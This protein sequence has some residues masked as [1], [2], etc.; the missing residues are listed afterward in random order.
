MKSYKHAVRDRIQALLDTGLTQKEVAERLDFDNPNNVSMLMSDRYPN[1]ILAPS[2]L[3][4]LQKVCGLTNCEALS[5]LRLLADSGRSGSKAMHLDL[6]TVDWF[7]LT[8]V[9]ARS[10]VI[11]RRRTAAAGSPAPTAAT[12]AGHV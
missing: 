1:T 6:A 3:P 9:R 4:L 5:L 11:A 10:E 2:K 7:I 12:G 8:T